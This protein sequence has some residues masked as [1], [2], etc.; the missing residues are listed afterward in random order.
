MTVNS[1]DAGNH[2]MIDPEECIVCGACEP[3]CSVEAIYPRTKFPRIWRV[4]QPR[5]PGSTA[6]GRHPVSVN[7][8]ARG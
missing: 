8:P 7:T 4:T 3:E 2:T 5:L 6:R 1:Y